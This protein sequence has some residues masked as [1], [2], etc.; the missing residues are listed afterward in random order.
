MKILYGL[1]IDWIWIGYEFNMD[2]IRIGYELWLWIGHKV[3]IVLNM[4]IFI[5][6]MDYFLIRDKSKSL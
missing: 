4:N 2:G 6:E 5:K 1:D 3:Q